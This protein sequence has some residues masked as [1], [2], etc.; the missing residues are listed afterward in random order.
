MKTT[1]FNKENIYN[2]KIQN[3]ILE[4]K[5][6]C[7]LEGL[8]M[9]VAVCVSND[10]NGTVY[11]KDAVSANTSDIDLT[12]DIIPGLINVTLGFETVLPQDV[13][14]IDFE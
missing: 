3:L 5:K 13:P 9:F 6:I 14:T 4:M 7:T 1:V 12:N 8:P 2:E 10:E 11:K